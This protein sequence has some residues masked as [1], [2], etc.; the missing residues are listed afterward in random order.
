MPLPGGT[1]ALGCPEVTS[2]VPSVEFQRRSRLFAPSLCKSSSRIIRLRPSAENARLRTRPLTS[3]TMVAIC[4]SPRSQT[5]TS[6]ASPSLG[7]RIASRLPSGERA[8][9]QAGRGSPWQ[10]KHLCSE[11]QVPED[12]HAIEIGRDQ[13]AA[14]GEKA[15]EWTGSANCQHGDLALADPSQVIPFKPALVLLRRPWPE[16]LINS[17]RLNFAAGP[18]LLRPG[19]LRVIRRPGGKALPR[20]A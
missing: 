16:P 12:R 7:C 20:S 1:S 4:D 17:G 5:K 6:L 15:M 8:K 3:A 10:A 18:G 19:H 14:V 13:G 11:G 9:T 2:I